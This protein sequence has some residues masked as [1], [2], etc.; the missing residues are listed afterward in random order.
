[1]IKISTFLTKIQPVDIFVA[2]N[3]YRQMYESWITLHDYGVAPDYRDEWPAIALAHIVCEQEFGDVYLGSINHVE[4]MTFGGKKQILQST[5]DVIYT[6]FVDDGSE[7]ES[8]GTIGTLDVTQFYT[9]PRDTPAQLGCN[10]TTKAIF[11]T[12][13][14]IGSLPVLHF[15]PHQNKFEELLTSLD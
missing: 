14:T 12:H 3:Y 5:I 7:P 2:Q 10:N 1:M 9:D 6:G 8:L 15:I 11:G 4:A 13:A